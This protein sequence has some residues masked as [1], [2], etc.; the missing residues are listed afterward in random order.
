MSDVGKI[1]MV[2]NDANAGTIEEYFL[3]LAKEVWQ[4]ELVK[5]PFGNS[6]WQDEV[7]A[8]LARAGLICREIAYQDED[9]IDYDYDSSEGDLVINE[10]FDRV[11]DPRNRADH[12][13]NYKGD[14][15]ALM[16]PPLC[17][18]EECPVSKAAA[19]TA[20]PVPENE[21]RHPVWVDV[22]TGELKIE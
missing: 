17:N 4:W 6:G 9:Y 3:R 7:Y 5:R 16:H 11:L 22:N 15:F 1:T 14:E 13:I 12:A 18:R 20:L 19:R 10:W 2:A 8:S 21:G